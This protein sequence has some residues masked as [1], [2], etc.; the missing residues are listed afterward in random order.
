M[1]N[2]NPR[3][4]SGGS[5]VRSAVRRALAIGAIAAMGAGTLV[6]HATPAPSPKP[7]AT[8][9]QA[10]PTPP[11]AKST[12]PSSLQTIV[13]T[14]TMIPRTDTE[15]A[16]AITIL[17]TSTLRHLGVVNVE[18]A[19]NT[20]TSNVPSLNI[21]QSVGTFS[22]GG[23]YADLRD[24]GQGRTL[25]LLDGHRLANNAF[26]GNAVD[27]SGIPF[28]AI[29]SVQVLREGASALYGADAIAGVV[30]FITK[31]NYQGAEIDAQINHPQEEGG[32]SGNISFTFGHGSLSRDGYNFMITADFTRQQEL[33]ATQRSFT[34]A[35]FYPA[36]GVTNTNGIGTWPATI[37]DANGNNWQPG[38]PT[39][40]GNDFLTTY[41][42]SC[43]YRYS[44]ATDLIPRSYEA[45]ALV[46]FTK[47]LPDNNQV[48]LQY[49]YTRSK[50]TQWS[51]PMF[52]EFA[53]TPQADPTYFPT[54]A[55]LTCEGGAANCTAPPLLN[56]P[57]VATWSD[58][59]NNRYGDNINTEQRALVTFSGHNDGWNY[60][61][62]LNY[63]KNLN[64]DG[65]VGG[66]PNEAALASGT[67]TIGSNTY[68]IISN[69]IN[70]FG[71]NSVQGQALI[72]GSYVN[73]VYQ[74]G[75]MRRWSVSGHASHRVFHWFDTRHAAILAVG[76][77]VRGDR[78]QSAT[79]PY[80]NLVSAATGLSDF[81]IQGSRTAQAVFAELDVPMGSH[82]NVD[83][84]DR[85]DHYSDFGS[86]NNGKIAVRYQPSRY[87]TFRGAASTGFRAPTLYDLYDPPT[88]AASSAGSV[89]NYS[90]ICQ[91]GNYTTLWSSNVC[92][93]QGLGLFGGNPHLKPEKS[94]NFDIGVI[95]APVRNLGITI[96][97]YRILVRD[98][99]GSVPTTDIYGNPTQF[100]DLIH[101]NASGT[102]TP[103]IAE[104]A[105][106]PSGS[107]TAPSCGYVEGNLAN[108]G[109]LTTDGIDLSV[110]YAQRTRVGEFREDLSGTAITQFEV[111]NYPGGPFI[112]TVGW[113]DQGFEPA[114]RWQSLLRLDWTSPDGQW[115][116]GLSNRLFSHYIDEFGTGPTNTGPQRI[117]GTQSTWDAYVSDRPA[118]GLTVLFGIRN[119]F[120]TAPP[121]SNSSQ[122]NFAAGYNS[123]FSNPIMRDFYLNLTYRFL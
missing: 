49:F 56:Q 61:A 118:R 115:G 103:T 2:R 14:G 101:A 43:Q 23:T 109:R 55:G 51:G 8:A 28:S 60:T 99:I 32:G 15:T 6:A 95:I 36:L 81:A 78:F 26:S 29:Q 4:P 87:I 86:T 31:R 110:K 84:S 113:F 91:S 42:G 71:P 66:Y 64:T 5:A 82:L 123:L 73:G 83:L 10:G 90:P 45:S 63:S 62:S 121:F 92:N 79:T 24:L 111:Q 16:E 102:L 1:P 46:S 22:G 20:V 104:S 47:A 96:D 117:V 93:N 80:N 39:C 106:C 48:R 17:R 27:L 76:A 74:N 18:Q 40:A 13:V 25:V 38:Y 112:N 34:A 57:I 44:A 68:P 11:P 105:Q 98:T 77:S 37:I 30:N 59:L 122:G 54:A 65:N 94:E 116:G 89:V 21:A 88:L 50:A 72:N 33:R 120:N 7:L 70:P 52:Y 100:A 9:A 67:V 108:V 19:L 58:P 107:Y 35:G 97:Y 85:E 119:L 41:F 75:E 69:L 3:S 114:P 53:M 12:Q